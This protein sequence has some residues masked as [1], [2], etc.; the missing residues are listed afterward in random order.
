MFLSPWVFCFEWPAAAI[1]A[2]LVSV[3]LMIEGFPPAMAFD[4]V[5]FKNIGDLLQEYYKVYPCSAVTLTIRVGGEEYDVAK[6]LKCDD[7]VLT[8][9][10]FSR[11]KS[12][13]ISKTEPCAEEKP[14]ET[15]AWPALTVPYI[16][17]FWVEFNPSKAASEREI[18]FTA[19]S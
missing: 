6:I 12:H 17:I 19:E 1:A 9:S 16:A 11:E 3:P 2:G 13:P 10:Y 4:K 14:A 15:R 5:F 18:G 7:N 8:F